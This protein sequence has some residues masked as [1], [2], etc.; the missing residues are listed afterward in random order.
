MCLERGKATHREAHFATLF[1]LLRQGPSWLFLRRL[2]LGRRLVLLGEQG[3]RNDQLGLFLAAGGLA[4]GL[5]RLLHALAG[6]CTGTS[7]ATGGRAWLAF[8]IHTERKVLKIDKQRTQ[9]HTAEGWGLAGEWRKAQTMLSL[10]D[11]ACLWWSLFKLYLLTCLQALLRVFQVFVVVLM[12]GVTTGVSG[13]CCCAHGGR[14]YG[15]FRCLLLCSWWALLQ[16]F[17]VFVAVLM[18]GVTTGVSGVCCCAH[19]GHYY[20]CF[21]CLLLCSCN[22]FGALINSLCLLFFPYPLHFCLTVQHCAV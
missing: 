3:A 10:T 6:A 18:A 13:V 19:G 9:Q 11:G 5:G 16:V 1:G 17:Q 14:Y 15:C 7:R 21:R 22:V 4:G 12:A 2:L 20:G 8:V